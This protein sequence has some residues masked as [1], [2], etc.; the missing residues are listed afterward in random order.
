M[1]ASSSLST[2]DMLARAPDDAID[3]TLGAALIAKDVYADLDVDALIRRFDDLA[4][5]L[6]GG[7]LAG[8]P[9]VRQVE[10][11]SVRFRELGFRGKV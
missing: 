9:L 2:F 10:E 8:L 4:G 3:I 1:R 6:K 11:V 5:P 7:A